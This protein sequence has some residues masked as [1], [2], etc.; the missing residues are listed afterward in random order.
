MQHL[1]KVV[2]PNIFH[3]HIVYDGLLAQW[4]PLAGSA[5]ETVS[6]PQRLFFSLR[7]IN[8]AYIFLV[9]VLSPHELQHSGASGIEGPFRFDLH[10]LA[11]Y[12][13]SQRK[14]NNLFL[15][16][17]FINTVIIILFQGMKFCSFIIGNN[18]QVHSS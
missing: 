9:L 3:P 6:S 17:L 10:R 16:I 2:A 1:Q 7:N 11:A 5:G 8:Q 18:P 15:V 14:Y 4:T 12:P 13:S